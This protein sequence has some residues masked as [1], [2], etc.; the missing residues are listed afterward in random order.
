MARRRMIDPAIWQSEDFSG[1]S[2]LAKL[3]FIGMF[4]NADDEGRGRAKPVYIKSILFPYDADMRTTDIEKSLLEIGAKMSVTLYSQD[5]NQYYSF[6]NWI[7]WQRVDKPQPSK[8][9]SVLAIP[10]LVENHSGT[11]PELVENGSCLKERK[12]KERN[13]YCP[14]SSDEVKDLFNRI[15]AT[16][17]KVR[18]MTDPRK[19]AVKAKNA[20]ME[21]FE[22][23][24][25]A[26]DK[27]DF[28]SGR[29]GKWT[30]CS[31]DWVLKPANWQKIREG[32][33]Q[34]KAAVPSD[35]DPATGIRFAN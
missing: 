33:Y 15:C 19:A 29:D 27:S 10:E 13:I 16:L 3:V 28:L 26:V 11:I 31:F 2:L 25:C 21:E 23:V 22:E 30:N 12:G 6:D 9:P 32:N 8:I 7:K 35:R 4:S 17:P 5:G 34:N 14:S 1:L 20:S 24:F 18:E